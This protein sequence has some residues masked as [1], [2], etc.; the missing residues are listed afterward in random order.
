MIYL[1]DD[2]K[3]LAGVLKRDIVQFVQFNKYQ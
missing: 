3:K 1:D 2:D